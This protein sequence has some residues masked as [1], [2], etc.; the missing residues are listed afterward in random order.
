MRQIHD[1][2]V[3]LLLAISIA[4]KRHAAELSEV[5]A[6][7]EFLQAGPADET[8]LPAAFVRLSTAGL[9]S[10]VADSD[11][12]GKV[13][14]ALTAVAQELLTSPMRKADTPTRIFAVKE[15]LSGYRPS[16]DQPAID[17]SAGQLQ[18]AQAE[19]RAGQKS[20]GRSLLMPKP[21]PPEAKTRGPGFK[22]R[23]PMPAKRRESRD[24]RK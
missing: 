1:I 12:P 4:G 13:R 18:L 20:S 3:I 5:L 7:I 16:D 24:P 8:K 21:K 15:Q 6:A 22:L 9:I 10:A 11:S 14:Y 19:L 23:K 17:V 2:D